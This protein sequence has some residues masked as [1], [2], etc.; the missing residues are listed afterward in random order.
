MVRFRSQLTL[1]SPASA[2]RAIGPRQ[3]ETTCSTPAPAAHISATHAEARC[4]PSP[5]LLSTPGCAAWETTAPA[6][7]PSPDAARPAPTHPALRRHDSEF[8]QGN[9][10]H[11]GEVLDAW[12]Q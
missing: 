6:Q 7:V 9:P 10:D 4:A 3:S 5:T 2:D 12:E 8:S 1:P 11:V